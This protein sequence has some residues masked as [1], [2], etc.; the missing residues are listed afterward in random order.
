MSTFYAKEYAR[1]RWHVIAPDGIP[2]YDGS[3]NGDDK[4]IVFTDEDAA[5]DCVERCNSQIEHTTP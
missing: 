5:L 1:N 2:I 3:L 4:P